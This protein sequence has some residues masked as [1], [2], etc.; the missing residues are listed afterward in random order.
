MGS[1]CSPLTG[2]RRRRRWLR[3]ASCRRN[4][5]AR[6]TPTFSI[7]S[8]QS[9]TMAKAGD[10][11]TDPIGLETLAPRLL[12]V[13]N[14]ALLALATSWLGYQ[15]WRL[16]FQDG[17]IGAIDLRNRWTEVAEFMAGEQVYRKRPDA[18]YP[19]ASY[20]FMIPLIGWVKFETA[21]G[22]WFALSCLALCILGRLVWSECKACTRSER[23]LTLLT[24]LA[25]YP[26]G[27]TMGNGQLGLV[28]I[29]CLIASLPRLMQADRSI[30]ED[31][32]ITFIFLGALTKPSLGAFFFWIVLFARGGLRPAAMVVGSYAVLTWAASLFHQ[33][34]PV[35]V[36]RR[37]FQGG[38]RGSK[39]GATYGSGGIH[40]SGQGDGLTGQV[41]DAH[42][43]V[44]ATESMLRI[45]NINLHSVLSWMGERGHIAMASF[46]ALLLLGVWVAWHRRSPIWYQ[47]GVTAI[48]TRL[49]VYHAWYDDVIMLLPIIALYR[50]SIGLEGVSNPQR[51]LAGILCL[52]SV[53]FLLAPGGIY[54]LPV[55]LS[56]FYVVAQFLLWLAVLV[57]LAAGASTQRRIEPLQ[58][59]E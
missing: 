56:N 19:P 30:A 3:I 47:I 1:Q 25:A 29:L 55:M 45:E 44:T 39:W 41:S 26:I 59:I 8:V 52:A 20:L 9:S 13:G 5:A 58:S 32:T 49:G 54:L 51:R 18:V 4:E 23:A 48:V 33:Q 11:R 35:A 37:W 6:G 22:I 34:G 24:V 36:M 40:P 14:L 42:V 57:Y 15:S 53:L 10:S 7:K 28:V 21:R 27:A 31:L 43:E 16:L 17:P 12:L 38:V 50:I 2:R 46:V